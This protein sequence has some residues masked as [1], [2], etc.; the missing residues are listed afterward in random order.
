M[1]FL[2][3]S[4]SHVLTAI[5]SFLSELGDQYVLVGI[6]GFLYW[7][8][9]K[10]WGKYL[11]TSLGPVQILP[12]MFKNIARRLRPYMVIPSIQC[13]KPLEPD[14]DL[15]NVTA[16]GYSFPSMHSAS[17]AITYGALA[18]YANRRGNRNKILLLI[19]IITPLLVA[20]SRVYVGVHFPTDVLF[21]LIFGLIFVFLM[22]FA[23]SKIKDHRIIYLVVLLAGMPGVFFCTS[24]DY[25]NSYGLVLG[26]YLGFMFE[27]RF[28]N[29]KNTK[30][31]LIAIVRTVIG[32]ALFLILNAVFK[33]PF[34][35]DFLE[36]ETRLVLMVRLFRYAAVS[37]C[38]IGVYPM[39]FKFLKAKKDL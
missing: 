32:G 2:Q 37:F 21:G 18:R 12:P 15:M 13:L 4:G 35:A 31:I 28:V 25:F 7:G 39:I 33:L 26:G 38:V 1:E 20:W 22:D 27:E 8:V 3:G 36:S 11:F 16:Q 34:S 30:S 9:N 19:G 6:L 17:A 5:A 14:Y 29:F 10:E 23:Q 24:H